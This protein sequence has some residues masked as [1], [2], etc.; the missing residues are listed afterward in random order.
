[1]DFCDI[2][3]EIEAQHLADSLAA[4]GRRQP[5]PG[6]YYVNG[7]AHCRCCLEPIPVAR[8]RAIPGVGLCVECAED[9]G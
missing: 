3:S 6:P 2:A 8:L 7:V 9:A 5:D 1:M 4:A